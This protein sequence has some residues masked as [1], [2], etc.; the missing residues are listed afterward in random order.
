MVLFHTVIGQLDVTFFIRSPAVCSSEELL[1][2]QLQLEQGIQ[3][4]DG[5]HQAEKHWT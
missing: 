1:M 3:L 4:F 2:E 5:S